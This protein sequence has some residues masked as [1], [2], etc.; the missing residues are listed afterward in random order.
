[1]MFAG[2][3]APNTITMLC[4]LKETKFLLRASLR[5]A[6]NKNFV[7]HALEKCYNYF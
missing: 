3:L 2:N 5:A 1:M 6:L 7:P 4:A